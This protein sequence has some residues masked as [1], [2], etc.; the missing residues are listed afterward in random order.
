MGLNPQGK[1]GHSVVVLTPFGHPVVQEGVKTPWITVSWSGSVLA[2]RG[3]R[4]SRCIRKMGDGT[5]L[6][7]GFGSRMVEN[8]YLGHCPFGRSHKNRSGANHGFGEGVK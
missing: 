4:M 8:P 7:P 3:G 1:W 6:T 5:C 2:G